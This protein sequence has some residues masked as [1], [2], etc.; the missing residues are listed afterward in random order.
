LAAA[1]LAAVAASPGTVAAQSVLT[2]NLPAVAAA[3][4]AAF[5]LD[6]RLDLSIG[7]YGDVSTD[8]AD[9]VPLARRAATRAYGGDFAGLATVL[10]GDTPLDV[11]AALASGAWCV[12]VATGRTPAAELRAAGAHVVLPDLADTAAVAAAITEGG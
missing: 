12:G 8:R 2:G 10:V 1:A 3:K 9:L 5:G 6:A 7:A 11:A 4:L